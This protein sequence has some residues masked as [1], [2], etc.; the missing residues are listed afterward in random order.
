[1]VP[2]TRRGRKRAATRPAPRS[3]I[4]SPALAA[5]LVGAC[6]VSSG[7][8]GDDGFR[9]SRPFEIDHDRAAEA[10][11]ARG[12][13]VL[14]L[15]WKLRGLLGALAGLFVPSSGDGLL[16]LVEPSEDRVEIQLLITA[17]KHEGEY[18]LYGA[19]IDRGSGLTE[20]IWSSYT[21]KESRRDREDR[22]HSKDVIDVASGIFHLRRDPPD[23]T[24]E[25]Q[26]WSDGKLYPVEVVP[27]GT[28]TRKISGKRIL[29]RGYAVRGLDVKGRPRFKDKY[30]LYF[31]ED[32]AA[33]PVEI[34]GKRGLVSVRIQLVDPEGRESSG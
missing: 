9:L 21:Y 30:F 22:I 2:F 10:A 27:L 34:I 3:R 18:F 6:L 20:A 31:A 33:T 14:H 32:G 16:T 17:P 13:E 15:R 12:G 28:E 4:R 7:L 26:V 8:A 24:I 29:V 25:L 11:A 23:E 5:V 1:M 19:E